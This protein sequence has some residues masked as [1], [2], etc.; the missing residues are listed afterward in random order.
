MSLI[1]LC[2]YGKKLLIII[3]LSFSTSL[4]SQVYFNDLEGLNHQKYWI[5]LSTIDSGAAH[6][7][8][9]LSHTDSLNPYGLG[10]EII[11]PQELSNENVMLS[12]GGYVKSNKINND[13]IFVITILDSLNKELLW[14]GVNL[15]NTLKTANEWYDFDASIKFPEAS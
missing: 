7:G 4:F 3:F 5:G 6:S 15:S 10:I 9:Y 2:S 1:N 12:V 8:Y 14:K 13:A 11:I